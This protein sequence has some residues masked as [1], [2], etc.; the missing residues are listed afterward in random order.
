MQLKKLGNQLLLLLTLAFL[1][2]LMVY[3]PPWIV[4]QYERVQQMGDFAAY[5]YLTVV[6]GGAILLGG[7]T[8]TVLITLV[9]RTWKK[10][11]A[12]ARKRRNPSELSSKDK[13]REVDDNLAHV[14]RLQD[15]ELIDEEVRRELQASLEQ[16]RRKR[17]SQTLEIVAFG[18]ISSGK[19]SLLNALAGEEVFATDAKGGTTVRRGE[20]VWPGSD[21]VLLVD[22]PGLGEVDGELHV[23]EAARAA[24]DAD[25]VLMVV[26]GPLRDAE[27]QLLEQLAEMEKRILLCVNKSDWFKDSDRDRLTDQLHSQTK[28]W[29]DRQDIVRVSPNPAPRT[30]VRV[31]ANGDEVEEQ[32]PVD[33]DISMLA[34]RMLAVVR[35]DGSDLLLSNLLLKSRGLIEEAQQ[36]VR[37]DL[38]RRAWRLVDRYSWGAG[39]AAAVSPL[40]LL[41]LAA[42]GAITTK[43]VFDLSNVY[44]HS[45]DSETAVNLLSQLGK[46]LLAILGVSAATPLI[47]GAV[48]SLLKTVPGAGTIA[49]GLLQGVVQALITRWI[50]AV[51]IEYFENESVRGEDSLAI[52]ARKKWD[53]LTS[54]QEL[55]KL[56]A[57]ARHGWKE[58]STRGN[59][60]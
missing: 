17:E 51:F 25:L 24:K 15:Q 45:I 10:R 4:Q 54:V 41:D 14:G 19:S 52:V 20:V 21:R 27:S 9:R 47:A 31:L 56:V 29:I 11:Q 43:M 48:A 39:G 55:A 13:Q 35:R 37:D 50:G 53:H 12:R 23:R 1:G 26:D 38:H 6:G 58:E 36:K 5:A 49:G 40:P 3:I 34:K 7:I 2:F 18:T 44:Q 28:A 30:V 8:L 32:V 59:A 46:N 42:G 33:P 60:E 16:F 22:T 57:A